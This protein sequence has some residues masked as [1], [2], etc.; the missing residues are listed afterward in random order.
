MPR[1]HRLPFS[2]SLR[3]LCPSSVQAFA[4]RQPGLPPATKAQTIHDTGSNKLQVNSRT[5]AL[6]AHLQEWPLAGLP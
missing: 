4:G 2:S 3:P 6:L 1:T 5:D